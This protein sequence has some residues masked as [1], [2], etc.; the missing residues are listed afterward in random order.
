MQSYHRKEVNSLKN[1]EIRRT[2]LRT[3]RVL[4]VSCLFLLIRNNIYN[5]AT[6]SY[7]DNVF[8]LVHSLFVINILQDSSQI[9]KRLR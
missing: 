5:L 9:V 7:S 6:N 8:V 4:I 3:F 1:R 2:A